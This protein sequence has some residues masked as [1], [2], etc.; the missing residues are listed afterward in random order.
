M[1]ALKLDDGNTKTKRHCP[2]SHLGI[3][4]PRNSPRSSLTSVALRR[5]LR[6]AQRNLPGNNSA[7]PGSAANPRTH[8]IT[9]QLLKPSTLELKRAVG[10]SLNELR[11]HVES[12]IERAAQPSSPVPNKPPWQVSESTSLSPAV[13]RPLG[14]HH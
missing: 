7:M 2:S 12:Q 8:E 10:A 6:S 11:A 14:S 3:T 13:I 4:R 9:E 5:R 1:F